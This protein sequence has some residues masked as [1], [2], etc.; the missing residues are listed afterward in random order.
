MR[1]LLDSN[2]LV[3]AVISPDG[4]A[5]AII[6]AIEQGSAHTLLVSEHLRDE[7]ADVLRRDRM[8]DRWRVTEAS[9]RAFV[10]RLDQISEAVAIAPLPPVIADPKD[11]AVIEAAIAGRADVLCT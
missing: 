6:E 8:R 9:V 5:N 4:A 3:R 10:K 2:L 7:V 1:V 11:Q